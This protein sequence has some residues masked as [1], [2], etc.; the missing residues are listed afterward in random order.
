MDDDTYRGN[1][2]PLFSAEVRDS[3][4]PQ[5]AGGVVVHQ[6]NRVSALKV[7]AREVPIP[8]RG[9]CCFSAADAP[10]HRRHLCLVLIARTLPRSSAAAV[11][12]LYL[13]KLL[14]LGPQGPSCLSFRECE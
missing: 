6:R 1:T 4:R 7:C 8:E 12:F 5:A 3:I 9:G 2:W 14:K 11:L 13:I 10:T